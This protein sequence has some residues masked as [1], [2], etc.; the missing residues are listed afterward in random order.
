[1]YS[2]TTGNALQV[3]FLIFP[4][5]ETQT[6]FF[7]HTQKNEFMSKTHNMSK[8]THIIATGGTIE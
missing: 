7:T 4:H 1:M 8:F 6:H 5:F 2:C 3:V